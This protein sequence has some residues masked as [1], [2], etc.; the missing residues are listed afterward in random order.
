MSKRN[1]GRPRP[2]DPSR[3]AAKRVQVFDAAQLIGAVENI[4][5]VAG[6]LDVGS[7]QRQVGSV[8]ANMLEVWR[9]DQVV[10]RLDDEFVDAIVSS[11]TN[12]PMVP[13]WL[14]RLPFRSLAASLPMPL[15]LH[16]GTDL[17]RYTGFVAT[18]IVHSTPTGNRIQ[19][20]YRSFAKGDGIRFLWV[21]TV[22]GDPIP[23][24]QTVTVELRGKLA[25]PDL[26]LAGWISGLQQAAESQGHA[27]G[28][29]LSVLVPLSVQALLYLTAQEPDLDWIPPEQLSRPQQ[30]RTAVVG[31]VGWRVGSALRSW[32]SIA[33]A[34]PATDN[35]PGGSRRSLPPHIRRA[36]W[37]RVRMA[38]RDGA[39]CIVGDVNGQHGIDW[40][41]QLRWYPPTPVNAGPAPVVRKMD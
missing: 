31:N 25:K 36:H 12:V 7:D 22:D 35:D 23:R 40:E 1:R 29:E 27:W 39:G 9:G 28:P 11:D 6:S 38:V 3:R 37:H 19:T 26:T 24:F 30:L 15:P 34:S 21:Y 32:R 17:C 5:R 14:A 33:P 4:A 2:E 41:Y 18:G 13:D 16:D 20:Y 10:V 8:A